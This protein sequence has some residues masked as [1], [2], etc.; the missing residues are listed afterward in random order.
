MAHHKVIYNH[1]NTS[2]EKCR[3]SIHRCLVFL[4]DLARYR[5]LHSQKARKNF[6]VAEGYYY[7][8]L[9]VMPENGNPHNQL[10]VLATYIEAETIAVSSFMYF[11]V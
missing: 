8:A 5:E 10:A 1:S 6:S 3:Q 11:M 4:G 2:Y 9:A 7:R